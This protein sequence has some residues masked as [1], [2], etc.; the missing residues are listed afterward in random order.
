[1]LLKSLELQGY[2]TFAARTLF[3]FDRGTTAIVGPNGSGKSNIADAIRW[4]LGEQSLNTLR[5]KKSGDMIFA[6]SDTRPRAGFAVATVVLDNSQGWLPVAYNEVSIT[7]KAYRSGDNEYYLN[8]NRVKLREISELLGKSG[9]SRRT[10][11]VIG[12]GLIDQ[13]LSLRPEERRQLFEEA[14]GI[15][16]YQ[17]RREQSLTR[18]AETQANLLRAQDIVAELEPRLKGLERQA[19]KANEQAGLYADLSNRLQVWYGYNWQLASAALETARAKVDACADR[20]SDEQAA[21]GRSEATLAQLRTQRSELRQQVETW[22]RQAG[23]LNSESERLGRDL[24][25]GEARLRVLSSQRD[26]LAAGLKTLQ[27]TLAMQTKRSDAARDALAQLATREAA[28]AQAVQQAQASLESRNQAR[29]AAQMRLQQAQQ[30]SQSLAHQASAVRLRLENEAEQRQTLEADIS[31]HQAAVTAAENASAELRLRQQSLR[32]QLAQLRQQGEALEQAQRQAQTALAAAQAQESEL[33]QRLTALAHNLH[34]LRS[35]YDVLTRLRNEGAGLYSGVREI[36]TASKPGSRTPAFQIVGVVSSLLQTPADLETAL[37]VALGGHLQDI[38]VEHWQDAEAAI[39]HLKRTQ[40]GRATFLPLDTLKAR[41]PATAPKLPGVIG[42]ACDLVQA[43]AR[44]TPVLHLLLGRSLIV[45][46]LPTA[47]RV[48]AK[49]DGL[50]IVTRAGEVVQSSGS[51]TGGSARNAKEGNASLLA[52]EREWRTLPQQ[53]GKLDIESAT[54]ETDRSALRAEA[55][56]AQGTLAQLEA[57]NRQLVQQRR[58]LETAQNDLARQLDR[59][60]QQAAFSR[61]LVEQAETRLRSLSQTAQTLRQQAETVQGQEKAARQALTA[62]ESEVAG[63]NADGLVA[64]LAEVRASA[65]ALAAERRNL[66]SALK[67]ENEALRSASHDLAARSQRIEQLNVEIQTLER[68]ISDTHIASGHLQAR[69]D[70]LQQQIQ[71]ADQALNLCESQISSLESEASLIRE[72]L[73]SAEGTLYASQLAEQRADDQLARLRQEAET[74]LRLLNGQ[75]G[76]GNADGASLREVELLPAVET[77]PA[78]IEGEISK[79]RNAVRRLGAVNPDAPAEYQEAKTRHQFLSEQIADLTQAVGLL[80]QVIAE[81]DGAMHRE[82]GKTFKAVASAFSQNFSR[83]FG[84]G[85]AKLVLV[86]PDNPQQ[87]GI[88]IIARPPGKRPQGLAALSGGERA[89]TAAALIFS[90]LEVSPTPFCIMDEVDA[91]LDEANIGR[92]RD[93]LKRLSDST[94]MIAITHNRGTI[95]A[96]DTIYGISMGPDSVSQVVSLKLGEDDGRRTT[97]DEG[98]P[99]G[100]GQR[101]QD[102]RPQTP[103]D[104]PALEGLPNPDPGQH[105]GNGRLPQAG[106]ELMGEGEPLHAKR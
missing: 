51:V 5:G 42:L 81:L 71:P 45:E 59:K 72:A 32:S 6:G 75:A 2:K 63:L 35:R 86:D 8:G 74:D 28:S 103:D 58:D 62:A 64:A 92:F 24:A 39:E 11:T 65:N 47:R 100:H 68:R 99:E 73:R 37:E 14:A 67:R 77:L 106:S 50:Q 69:M 66:E 82:F 104:F 101:T 27:A 13:A 95:E 12:Q 60:T 23:A 9:L 78:G 83:L 1:M 90:I 25:V 7:R 54:L 26:E 46:D 10:Y 44:L 91:A 4:V 93:G 19:Q 15:T 29:Q 79:L 52:R 76:A 57:Q 18:L 80:Q 87:S 34:G 89:L 56:A 48:L 41:P 96:A 36:L 33:A 31:Q 102:G 3:L 16:L 70:A 40:A 21:V 85:S 61:A 30:A 98:A 20:V 53:M 55:Q 38:V 94:Q 22:R 97:D 88:E 84:G 17:S 49:A 105:T 43:E